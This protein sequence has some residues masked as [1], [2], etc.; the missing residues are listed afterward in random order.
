[1]QPPLSGPGS[2]TPVSTG[3]EVGEPETKAPALGVKGR[4][5][6]GVCKRSSRNNRDSGPFG[7]RYGKCKKMGGQSQTY[8][9]SPLVPK[10]TSYGALREFG[11]PAATKACA[12]TEGHKSAAVT[13]PGQTVRLGSLERGY[14]KDRGQ[15]EYIGGDLPREMQPVVPLGGRGNQ[16]AWVDGRSRAERPHGAVAGCFV[17]SG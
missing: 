9:Q 16:K 13:W 3:P 14:W 15:R 5:A 6:R 1:M 8:S 10:C 4:G 11:V 2:G 12:S 7:C 17:S